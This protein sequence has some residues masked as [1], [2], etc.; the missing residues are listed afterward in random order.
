MMA[1]VHAA[2]V[3]RPS[4]TGS[5]VVSVKYTPSATVCIQVPVE[6]TNDDVRARAKLRWRSGEK[7]AEAIQRR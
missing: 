2:T 4:Q 3:I 5:W 1:G 7:E 6:D